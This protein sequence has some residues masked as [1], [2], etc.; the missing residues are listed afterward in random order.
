MCIGHFSAF[1]LGT[2]SRCL[3]SRFVIA[4]ILLDAT[5]YGHEMATPTLEEILP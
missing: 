4:I 2:F 1:K 5:R 3:V